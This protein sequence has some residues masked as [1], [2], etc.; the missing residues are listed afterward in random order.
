MKPYA[1][2]ICSQRIFDATFSPYVHPCT[3]EDEFTACIAIKC[4]R[5]K[6]I[7]AIE[8]PKIA[9]SAEPAASYSII[10]CT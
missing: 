1:C 4:P 3:E 7:L 6:R 10:A 9:A 8:F 2:P 5:C